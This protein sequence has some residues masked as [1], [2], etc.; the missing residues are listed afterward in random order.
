MRDTA[1]DGAGGYKYASDKIRNCKPVPQKGGFY[2]A[3]YQNAKAGVM[4][5]IRHLNVRFLTFTK[6]GYPKPGATACFADSIGS[7][8]G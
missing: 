2:E 3:L 5:Q 6:Q 7:L 1:T 8:C 4:T